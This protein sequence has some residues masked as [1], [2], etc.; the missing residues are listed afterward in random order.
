MK[1]NEPME[2]TGDEGM[3]GASRQFLTFILNGEEYGVDILRVQ[4]IKGWSNATHVPNSPDYVLGVINLRGEVIP[5]LD[6]RR[7]FGMETVEPGPTTV[8]IVARIER[9]EKSQYLGIVVDAVSDVH[10]IEDGELKRP[11][12]LGD[13][14]GRSLISGIATVGEKMIILLDVDLLLDSKLRLDLE[15]VGA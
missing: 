10:T 4:E 8:T 11:P 13:G 2:R 12:S 14:E 9:G 15:A 1:N 5:V 7:R 3:A 6:L